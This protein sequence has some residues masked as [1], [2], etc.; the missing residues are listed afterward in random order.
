MQI[1]LVVI[2]IVTENTTVSFQMVI[3]FHITCFDKHHI[4]MNSMNHDF[5][6]SVSY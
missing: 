3:A 6:L 2:L 4:K 1:T 5:F